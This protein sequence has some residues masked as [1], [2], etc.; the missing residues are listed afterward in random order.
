MI[1]ASQFALE[2]VLVSSAPSVG[3]TQHQIRTELRA[4]V[5]L[6]I[7]SLAVSGLFALLLAISRLPGIEK[8]FSW[9]LGFFAKGLVI[10]VVFSLVV[11]LLAVFALAASLA[12]FETPD[13]PIRLMVLGRAGIALV[14]L[15]FPLLFVPAFLDG[16]VASLNNYVPVIIHPAYYLGLGLLAVGVAL[17]V[18]RLFANLAGRPSNSPLALAMGAGG[19]I[20]MVA[21]VCIASALSQL[22]GADV[23]RS[24]HEQLFWGGGHVLQF[25]YCLLML[26]GWFTLIRSS[27]G[28][29][30]VDLDIF[31][32]AVLLL[33]IFALAAPIFYRVFPPF[34]M[35]QSEAFRRLQFALALPALLL[36][37][38]LLVGL[39]AARKRSVLPWTNP[40]FLAL[41]LSVIVFGAG[42]VMGLLISGSDT[43]TPAHYHGTIAGVSLACMGMI[44]SNSPQPIGGG[45]LLRAQVLL[46]GI[47]QFVACIGLF[48]AGGYGAPRKMPGGAAN[49]VDG[50]IVGLYLH[51]IGAVLAIAGGVLFVIT[52]FRALLRDEHFSQ[53]TSVTGEVFAEQT[54]THD[55]LEGKST[56]AQHEFDVLFPGSRPND[57]Q[58]PF[59]SR[60]RR[61]G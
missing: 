15:S 18:L 2:R 55:A 34:S 59:S 27:L 44:L 54:S 23:T 30:A 32:L 6:A 33:A 39:L 10:H 43:R 21:L 4:W 11:W 38:S 37:L 24:F 14:R 58:R 57:H 5:A 28:E 49:L 40:I 22:W 19:I 53:R 1:E 26:T 35:L 45:R 3:N 41:V 47:G 42:G 8:V 7:G 29:E 20:Y 51:G 60:S 46:F 56:G 9:P 17:P 12:V 61:R 52:V 16:S 48:L 31:R 36:A 50:A 25:L 13:R